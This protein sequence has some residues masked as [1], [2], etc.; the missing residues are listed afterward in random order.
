VLD[1]LGP[2]GDPPP[3][4]V[5]DRIDVAAEL[6][7]DHDLALVRGERLA[8]EFLV[9][10]GAIDF[11]GVEERDA[12]VHRG[13]DQRDH[14]L[15]VGLVAVA[16]G[17]AHAAQPDGGDLRAV[18]AQGALV[19]GCCSC[20]RRSRAAQGNVIEPRSDYRLMGGPTSTP[21]SALAPA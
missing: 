20:R 19:H 13:A 17:H 2:A 11:G 3:R 9:G 8:D 4:L 7:G 6:G 1:D 5:F 18:G 16:T 15:P 14:L 21:Q 12:A 10:V